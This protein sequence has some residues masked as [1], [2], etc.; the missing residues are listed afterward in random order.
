[1][2]K[3][4]AN[5]DMSSEAEEDVKKISLLTREMVN[6][7]CNEL[8]DTLTHLPKAWSDNIDHDCVD[9]EGTVSHKCPR[10]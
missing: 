3:R 5:D 10:C 8:V 1:M 7:R 4:V 6:V 9:I 2:Q